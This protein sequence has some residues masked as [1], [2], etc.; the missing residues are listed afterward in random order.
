M[1][2]NRQQ[3]SYKT[4]MKKKFNQIISLGH[5]CSVALEM[6]RIGLR[7][8]SYPFDWLI[9]SDFDKVLD[10]IE[11]RF[12]VFLDKSD[13]EQ[14]EDKNHYLSRRNNLHFYHDFKYNDVPFDQQFESVERKYQ[15]R[16][17]RFYSSATQ[18]TLF[19]RYLSASDTVE[20]MRRGG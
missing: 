2:F 9:T 11:N 6:E 1:I 5:F 12:D 14:E 3:L 13:L 18:P 4:S 19:I 16:I 20:S 17:D 10:L 7:N 15:R 8:D